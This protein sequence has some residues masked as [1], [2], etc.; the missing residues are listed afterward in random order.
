MIGRRWNELS[1]RT[2][3]KKIKGHT[4]AALLTQSELSPGVTGPPDESVWIFM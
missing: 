1:G 3:H 2:A 4:G